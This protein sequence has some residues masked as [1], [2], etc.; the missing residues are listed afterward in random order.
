MMC[1]NCKWYKAYGTESS[2]QCL[3]KEAES[4]IGGIRTESFITHYLCETMLLNK[5]WDHKLF[6]A[7]V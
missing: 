2:D 3:H 1:S 4:R 6:E 7:A 5:C